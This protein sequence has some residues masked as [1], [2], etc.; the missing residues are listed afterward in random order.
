M[1][2]NLEIQ[3]D[4]V[5]LTEQD[6]VS[7]RYNFLLREQPVLHEVEPKKNTTIL[8]GGCV[9][10]LIPVYVDY[11]D[12]FEDV[13]MLA[14]FAVGCFL[15]GVILTHTICTM[16]QEVKVRKVLVQNLDL[17]QNWTRPI[18]ILPESASDYS[19]DIR[20]N[21]IR[22]L[23]NDEKCLNPL[24]TALKDADMSFEYSIEYGFNKGEKMT[25]NIGLPVVGLFP[26]LFVLRGASD[27]KTWYEFQTEAVRIALELDNTFAKQWFALESEK[28]RTIAGGQ[29]IA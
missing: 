18:I 29:F 24:H 25:T 20:A 4:I 15:F 16:L 6:W 13:E 26:E 22:N 5:V 17:L 23:L 27:E 12:A 19:V 7:E 3:K 10:T 1:S 28:Y 2:K 21:E 14:L 9:A 8:L 11:V